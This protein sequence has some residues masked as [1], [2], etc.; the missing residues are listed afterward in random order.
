MPLN[1]INREL[2]N[3]DSKIIP[4]RTHENSDFDPTIAA[5][6]P[7]PFDEQQRWNQPQKGFNPKQKKMLWIALAVFTSLAVIVAGF[8]AY[9]WWQ[10]NAFHQDRVEIY[11]EGP[12]EADSTQLTQYTIHY[13]NNN[14]VTLKNTE[15]K[16]TYSENFQP[17]DNVNLKYLSPSSSNIFIGD[18]KPM[19]ENS[20]AIKG[21]FYAPKD[22]PVFLHASINFIPSNGN[23][24]LSMENQIGVNITAAPVLLVVTAPQQA[25]DGDSITYVIDYKNLDI[26][27][28]GDV[29]IRVDLPQGFQMSSAQPLPS[30]KDSYWYVGNLEADQGGKITIQGQIH[31]DDGESKN[32]M[33]SLGHVGTESN[34]VVFNKRDADTTIV[35]PVLAIKQTLENSD[36]NIINPGD[37]LRYAVAY[38][39]TGATGLRDA[40][41]SVQITGK[42]LDFSKINVN[43]GSYNSKTGTMTWKASDVP[44]LANIDPQSGGTVKFSIPVKPIIPIGNKLDKN[45][46]VTSIAKIDSPDIP[47]SNGSDK[48]IGTNTLELKLA[49]R[50]LFDTKGY[51]N[52]SKIKNT[53]PIP[54]K[55]G[56]QTTFTIHWSVIN[57]SN[58]ING[59]QV[60]SS[61]PSG[62]VWTGKV[63]PASEKVS[64]NDRTNQIIWN[65]GNISAGA[66]VLTPAR[67]IAFQVGVTPQNN[68]I[69]EPLVLVNKSVFTATDSFVGRDVT[70]LG[71]AKDTQLYEDPS[72]G[73]DKG[74]VAP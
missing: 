46:V 44:G 25:I 45:F 57:V 14:R 18:I 11:F 4:G 50:V 49:S 1:D 27:R 63:F 15:I 41:V 42:I 73:Y 13:K 52:D 26:K 29:Q 21:V 6:K 19:S 8:F 36:N 56:A 17:I 28:I 55:I 33:V 39:N 51:Y 64:Y 58:D 60:I 23:A 62:V 9:R 16:L 70:L 5:A 38:K 69:G 59:A 22:S 3:T 34:F 54:M 24:V 31:G 74:K 37:V 53:G 61:L 32:I 30:E 35:A 10:K 71:A 2:Y 20:T 68:Q 48:V 7:S 47:I 72:V 40:I 67:E 12:K 65:A 66:G 43:S